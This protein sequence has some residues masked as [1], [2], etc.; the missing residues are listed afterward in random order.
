MATSA[1]PGVA[2]A[3][4]GSA[5]APGLGRYVDLF[6]SR[7]PSD[8]REAARLHA[9][10][11]A[12]R[13]DPRDR[14]IGRR[15]DTAITLADRDVPVRV[16]LPAMRKGSGAICYFH[17]GA[18][19]YGSVAMLDVA[20]SAIAAKTGLTV[21]STQYR[22]LPENDL[23]AA[24]AD[25]AATLAWTAEQGD[26]MGGAG[27]IMLAGDSVGALLALQ[28]ALAAPAE[29]RPAALLLL[30]GAFAMEPGEGRYAPAADP[31]VTPDRIAATTAMFRAGGGADWPSVYDHPALA[32]LPPVH[33]VSAAL[34]P[35]AE[36]SRRLVAALNGVGARVTSHEAPGMIHGFARA[37]GTS[38][39]AW[40]ELRAACDAVMRF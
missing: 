18:F 12:H 11:L 23:A 26:L 4:G 3:S 20:T 15:F 30:Y 19:S 7:P 31:L 6:R 38:D 24:L 5:I 39:E 28:V 17:G 33:V 22:R 8:T 40:M 10:L 13:L 27:R 29:L 25:C 37:C 32:A 16:H 35:L 14:A 34:D 36:D 2:P 21:V 9:D 1:P